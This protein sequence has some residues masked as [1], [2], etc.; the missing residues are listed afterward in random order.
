[1]ALVINVVLPVFAIIACGYLAGR[2]GLLGKAGTDTLNRFV[3]YFALPPLFFISMARTPVEQILNWPFIAA[4]AGGMLAVAV[5]ATIGGY[6]LFRNRRSALGLHSFTALFGN[7]G[8]I[9]IPLFIAA[10]GE[11]QALPAILATVVNIPVLAAVVAYI[12]SDRSTSGGA[13][14]VAR[15]VAV[16]LV[17]NP[18]LL[19]AAAGILVSLAGATVPAPIANLS[20]ILG[21][22][23]APGALFALGLFLVGRPLSTGA[24]ELAWLTALKL[25]LQPLVT[26]W[27]VTAVLEVDPFWASSAVILSALPTGALVFVVAQRYGVYVQRSSAAILVSTVL[28]LATVTILLIALVPD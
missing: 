16:S 18:L 5:V 21:A 23:A 26:W 8:Y 11:D 13:L 22:S 7:T 27:L 12:E 1:M 9:G 10:F 17:R 4:Y 19:T 6:L 28:S 15:D 20:D 2:F 24:G 25:L 3:Y 14:G